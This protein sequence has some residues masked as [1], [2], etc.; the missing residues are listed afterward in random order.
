MI[1]VRRI[2]LAVLAVAAVVVFFGLAPESAVPCNST[3]YYPGFSC[4]PST[5]YS[6]RILDAPPAESRPLIFAENAPQEQASAAWAARDLLAII[7]LEQNDLIRAAREDIRRFDAAQTSQAESDERL[8]AL[9][10][11]TVLAISLW[12]ATSV[13]SKVDPI[14]VTTLPPEP[15]DADDQLSESASESTEAQSERDLVTGNSK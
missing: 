8:A 9:L 11:I 14:P 13:G 6:R 3:G 15:D 2:G 5:N 12:G 4:D 1:V 10:V 7:A